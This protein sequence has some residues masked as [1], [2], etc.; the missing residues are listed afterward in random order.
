MLIKQASLPAAAENF[1]T[2]IVDT[3]DDYIDA[4]ID[5]GIAASQGQIATTVA[6]VFGVYLVVY[7]WMILYGYAEGNVST[8][9]KKLGKFALI[10]ALA[11]QSLPYATFVRDFLWTIPENIAGVLINIVAT[12]D[13]SITGNI[14]SIGDVMQVYND[15]LSRITDKIAR[16]GRIVPDI[17]AAGLSL[18]MQVPVI[19][20]LFVV[21]ISKVGL[22]VM[23]VLG[24]FLIIT[25]LF[26]L[27]KG[28]FEGWL[29]QSLT[30]IMMA[31]LAYAI[32]A[33]L[34]S[35][36]NAF[37][38]DLAAGTSALKYT[39]ALPLALIAVVTS[40]IFTQIPSFS[41][42]I[43]GGIGLS[44]LGLVNRTGQS[45]RDLDRTRS[46]QGAGAGGGSQSRTGLVGRRIGRAIGRTSGA[47]ASQAQ[48]FGQNVIGPQLAKRTPRLHKAITATAGAISTA[49]A[50]TKSGAISAAQ[51]ADYYTGGKSAVKPSDR[52][53]QSGG[54]SAA[55]PSQPPTAAE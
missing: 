14:N 17:I 44:D 37:G 33:L 4:F 31:I 25:S 39:K 50:A 24:P 5:A 35:I 52:K 19:A 21:L 42:G 26:G 30:F 49:G 27:T 40:I 16:S 2:F 7:A 55:K 22:S 53:A 36:L 10:Y 11:T 32:I 8:I 23:I 29:R 48:Q 3:V 47:A 12:A 54:N 1:F 38:N 15:N 45:I 46:G 6:S 51:T 13:G 41:T 28:I 34:M 9:M 18:L 43:V 20:A